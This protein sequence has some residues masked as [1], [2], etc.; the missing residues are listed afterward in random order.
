MQAT[1]MFPSCRVP[2]QRVMAGFCDAHKLHRKIAQDI[3]TSA[4]QITPQGLTAVYVIGS[5]HIGAVKIGIAGDVLSRLSTLQT[6]FPRRLLLYGATY[7]SRRFAERIERECHRILT[8]FGMH[9][10]GEWFDVDQNDACEL[11]TKCASNLDVPVLTCFE[12]ASMIEMN[13]I[14]EA[15]P[16][17]II[18]VRKRVMHDFASEVLDK[19]NAI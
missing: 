17:S 4:G 12:Y 16:R 9:L 11:V 18:A 5:E 3:L 2:V 19:S 15:N 14:P 8:D 10:N 1:C 13:D 6:G 7:T